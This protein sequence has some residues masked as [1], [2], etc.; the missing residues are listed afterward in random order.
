MRKLAV[1]LSLMF[2]INVWSQNF[3]GQK[4]FQWPDQFV[5]YITVP[6]SLKNEDA[7]ILSE[8]L[9][10][11][12]G[13]IWKR[14]AIK[15]QNEEGLKNLR[16]LQLPENF[17]LTN[18]SNL[19]AQGRFKGRKDP[20][21]YSFKINYFGVR[22]LKPDKSFE[23]ITPKYKSEK[24]CWVNTSGHR[25]YDY[26]H[27][28][29]FDDLKVGDI[30]EYTY[31]ALIDWNHAQHI[32]FPHS[33]Y[34]KFNY[35]LKI[36]VGINS[37]LKDIELVYNYKIPPNAVKK[38]VANKNGD[39][40]RN[41]EY[42]FHYLKGYNSFDHIMPGYVLPNISINFGGYYTV[43]KSKN[44]NDYYALD[45]Y[46]W[47]LFVD[48]FK[49]SFFDKYH[50]N[51][52]KFIAGIPQLTDDTT[53]N[54]FATQLVDTLNKLKFVSAESMNYGDIP[55]YAIPSSE[56]LLKGRLTEE[57]ILKNYRDFLAEKNIFYYD[58]IVIDRRKSLINFEYRNMYN[59]ER[60][61]IV[62]PM[63]SSFKYY[64]PRYRGVTYLPDELPFY[65]E[66]TK[67]VL[68][69]CS[70]CKGASGK[71]QISFI[72]IPKST[73]NENARSESATIRVSTDSMKVSFYIKENLSGQ[74]ST[75]L[76]HYYNNDHIDSTVS[77]SFYKKCYDI[78]GFS[79]VVVKK[80][81]L[82]KKF[83]FRQTY[84]C[85]GNIKLSNKSEINIKDW[86]SFTWTKAQF[87]KTP[88]HE[89][90]TEFQLSDYYNLLFEFDKRVEI[91]NADDFIKKLGN[92]YFEI[93]SNLVKQEEKKYLLSVIVKVKQDTI[94]EKDAMKIMD[95]VSMLDHLNTLKLN[96]KIL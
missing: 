50:A 79:D 1:I 25:I 87:P 15:I 54:G 31:E 71:L 88:N 36:K 69:P 3:P 37:E 44:S 66:G 16:S 23:D 53:G 78:P 6:D 57:F 52:R 41:S 86:F 35:S 46:K 14:I 72:G 43:G 85:S 62:I 92:E 4:D 93:T 55:Q 24:V 75:L 56:Q 30:L 89:V 26:V 40:I 11:A 38:T 64:V 82:Q 18:P 58:G 74:F 61:L 9:I 67:C 47:M 27:N 49:N 17:D 22:I 90:Y 29:G 39:V 51:I 12:G 2:C 59:L 76:R 63:G 96:Y 21:I 7:V 33:V 5:N 32:I 91:T 77:E 13:S 68:M 34:P 81:T 83:P 10:V 95:F 84:N 70:Q 45:K 48:T 28:F 73:F 80:G 60:K 8:Q 19:Y 65:L 42:Y 94:A 20:F